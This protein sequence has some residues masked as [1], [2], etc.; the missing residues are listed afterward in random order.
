[1]LQPAVWVTLNQFLQKV[2]FYCVILNF[3]LTLAV[4]YR[5]VL[6]PLWISSFISKNVPYL[7]YVLSRTAFHRMSKV[8][9]NNIRCF[10][11]LVY[12]ALLVPAMR[13]SLLYHSHLRNNFN[14]QE[15][16]YGSSSPH[17]DLRRLNYHTFRH[18]CHLYE[19]SPASVLHQLLDS[20]KESHRLSVDIL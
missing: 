19:A 16:G 13:F 12:G 5:L 1:M 6:H 20:S 10:L 18:H 9:K 17:R 7:Y 11:F 4:L 15:E 3:G 2:P 14:K 8:I